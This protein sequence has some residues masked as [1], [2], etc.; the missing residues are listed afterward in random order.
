MEKEIKL[1]CKTCG[2][3]IIESGML[4]VSGDEESVAYPTAFAPTLSALAKAYK[5]MHG[6]TYEEETGNKLSKDFYKTFIHLNHSE[7]DSQDNESHKLF[8]EVEVWSN[9][10]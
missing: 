9:N 1:N 8:P 2:V 10:Q 5:K 3:V 7:Y 6:S 4:Y